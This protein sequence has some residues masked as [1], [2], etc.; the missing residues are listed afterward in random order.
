MLK[1]FSPSDIIQKKGPSSSSGGRKGKKFVGKGGKKRGGKRGGEEPVVRSGDRAEFLLS[2]GIPREKV[3]FFFF[4]HP[5][6]TT[7][8]KQQHKTT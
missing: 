4:S 2:S 1:S 5:N 8:L 7:Q 3:S 6:L